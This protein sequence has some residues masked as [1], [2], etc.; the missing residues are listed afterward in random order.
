MIA[1]RNIATHQYF[2]IDL[3]LVW[4][5]VSEHLGPLGSSLKSILASLPQ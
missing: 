2:G 4:A 1:F 5:I 3:D